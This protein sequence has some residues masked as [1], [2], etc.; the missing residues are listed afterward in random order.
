M[1]FHVDMK[2]MKLVYLI[3]Y[4]DQWTDIQQSSRHKTTSLKNYYKDS[5]YS[6]KN[7]KDRMPHYQT[8]HYRRNQFHL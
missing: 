2:A 1:H 8:L 3:S 6:V 4:R 5:T 7:L